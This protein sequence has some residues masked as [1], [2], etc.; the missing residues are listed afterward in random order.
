MF[1]ARSNTTIALTPAGASRHRQDFVDHTEMT[2]IVQYALV[3]AVFGEYRNPEVDVGL[4]LLRLGK[5]FVLRETRQRSQH[6]CGN[7][8]SELSG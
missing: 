8:E 2:I 6:A 3:S 1:A 5:G 4:Q 7:R